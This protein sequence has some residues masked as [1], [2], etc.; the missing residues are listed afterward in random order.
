MSNDGVELAHLRVLVAVAD[1][2]T[3]T[4]AAARLGLSQPAVSR[5]LAR[6]EAALGVELVRRTTRSLVLT[7]AGRAAYERAVEVLRSVDTMVDE[8]RGQVGP[9]RVGYSWAALG[10]YTSDVLRTWRAEHPEVALVLHRVDDR[11]GG[12]SAGSVDVAIRRDRVEEPGVRVEPIFDEGRMAVLPAGSALARQSSLTLADLVDETIAMVPSIGTTTLD[13]WPAGARPQRV[14][15]V[16]NTDE[17]LLTI[18]S[19]EAVGV[20]PDS[21]PTQ[22][23]HPGV[24]FVP[25]SD[26]PW[27]TVSLVWPTAHQHPAL[28]AFV[29]T[30]H[31]CVK[32]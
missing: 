31:R 26:A 24:R 25:L 11:S 30:V 15:E 19:G 29:A 12:L 21:T 20:T 4:D 6:F 23:R 5:S 9:L 7:D 27:L 32:S 1:A 28:A 17:W 3:V 13:L 8:A 22:H 18:A 14:V 2:G 16:T 10:P